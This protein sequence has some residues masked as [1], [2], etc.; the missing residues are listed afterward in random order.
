MLSWVNS[1]DQ[2]MILHFFLGTIV[3]PLAAVDRGAVCQ[4][5]RIPLNAAAPKGD[6][7]TRNSEKWS[8][9]HCVSCTA[10]VLSLA[11]F[12]ETGLTMPKRG[13]P[14]QSLIARNV[15]D[16]GRYNLSPKLGIPVRLVWKFWLQ[17]ARKALLGS[18]E[19]W[20][21]IAGFRV[22][23]AN[24]YTMEPNWRKVSFHKNYTKHIQKVNSRL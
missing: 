2:I 9:W 10:L 4:C 15:Q 21:R 13:L 16:E 3:S 20:T 19:I 6:L 22:L 8:S 5:Y 18:T 7:P 17:L 14:S 1:F 23:S 11:T 12:R 24:H